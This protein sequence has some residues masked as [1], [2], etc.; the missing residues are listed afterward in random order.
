MNTTQHLECLI[1]HYI[2]CCNKKKSHAQ[3]ALHAK[4]Y[5]TCFD[6]FEF[7]RCDHDHAIMVPS[8]SFQEENRNFKMKNIMVKIKKLIYHIFYAYWTRTY[9]YIPYLD[10]LKILYT[11]MASN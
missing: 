9:S 10:L 5:Y 2:L 6:I 11:H 8:K 1:L 4:Y 3:N 7:Q